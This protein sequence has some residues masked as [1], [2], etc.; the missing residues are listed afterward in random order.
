MLSALARQAG[1]DDLAR[2]AER[3]AERIVAG[4]FYV[5]CLGQFKRGKSTLLNALIGTAVLPMG[6]VPVTSVVTVVRHGAR[7]GARARFRGKAW[8]DVDPSA[9]AAYVSE[10][11]NPENVK[12]VEAAE[13]FVTSPLL[14]HGM[15]FVDTPGIGSVFGDNTDA[16]RDFVPDI[17]A[18]LVVLGADPPISGDELA[19][20]TEVAGQVDDVIFVLNKADRMPPSERAEARVFMERILTDRLGRRI[21]PLLEV[22][23]TERLEGSAETRDW[24]VLLTKLETLAR[25]AGAGLVET[26]GERGLALLVDRLIRELGEQRGALLRP[27]A[28]SERRIADLGTAATEAEHAMRDLAYL[29]DAEQDRLFERLSTQRDEFLARALPAIGAE[30]EVAFAGMAEVGSGALRAQAFARAQELY[31][32]WLEE[33]RSEEQPAAEREYRAAAQRF[34]DLA[35]AFLERVGR[36]NGGPMPLHVGTE[37]GLRMRSRLHYTELLTLTARSPWRW[38]WDCLRPRRAREQA[39]RQEVSA[40]LERLIRSNAARLINDLRE[41]V[42]ESRRQLEGEVRTSLRAAHAAAERALAGARAHRDAGAETVRREVARLD[43]LQRR[44]EALRIAA[45]IPKRSE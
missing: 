36:Q 12:G 20:V 21:T 27:V 9:L 5:A 23:A 42:I 3:L 10:L 34:V 29:F 35:N 44:C 28:E 15:C 31:R 14:A 2:E 19:L 24:P 8:Q 45:E 37:A 7:P 39:A 6:V 18:A 11:E 38:L 25:E 40:Y 26:A 41:R 30:L 1:T 13:V 17:D 16:T 4:R 43:D 32:P 22:S 33:W